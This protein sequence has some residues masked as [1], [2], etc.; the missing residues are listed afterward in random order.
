MAFTYPIPSVRSRHTEMYQKNVGN[1]TFT[2]CYISIVVLL[3]I[4][5][6][7]TSYISNA[8][9]SFSG[10]AMRLKHT[11]LTRMAGVAKRFKVEH[12]L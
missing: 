2:N 10:V 11:T 8:C 4:M 5:V 6:T 1:H 9:L 12:D 7:F 3:Q